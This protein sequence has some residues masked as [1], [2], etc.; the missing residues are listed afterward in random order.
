MRDYAK[1]LASL[2]EHYAVLPEDQVHVATSE[3]GV[4]LANPGYV[5]IR[6]RPGVGWTE[7]K[8]SFEPVYIRQ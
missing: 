6:Y 5:P 8:P 3:T 7:M 1:A 2:P 4:I